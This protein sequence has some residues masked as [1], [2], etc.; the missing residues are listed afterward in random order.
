MGA[1]KGRWEGKS[2]KGGRERE[3]REGTVL[4]TTT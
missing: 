3:R 1:L 2:E 4:T